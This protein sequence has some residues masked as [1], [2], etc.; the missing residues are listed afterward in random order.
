M[1]H[2]VEM[3]G[4]AF[5]GR[6]ALVTGANRG[7]GAAVARV[8]AAHGASVSLLVRDEAAGDAVRRTLPGRACVVVADVT[9][10]TA[11]RA[12]CERAAGEL[13][14]VHI[15]VNNAG[16]VETAPFTRSD[17]AL[18]ARMLA[19]HLYGPLHCTQAVLPDMVAEGFGR[20]VNIASTAGVAGAAYVSAYCAAKHALVGL[21]RSLAK[22][23]IGQG[24]T[25]NAVCPGYTD[26][27]LVSNSI[28]RI[29]SRTGRS[30]DHAKAAMLA[31]NPLGRFIQ[32]DEVAAAVRWLCE[33][34][35][36]SVTGQTIMIDG[37]ELA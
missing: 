10:E 9:D 1:T 37:G 17:P 3:Q 12:A 32:P 23:V 4:N 21:T 20:V 36:G 6:H 18:F 26:T 8:L 7:I 14:P 34:A 22:E 13:G 2:A 15:L 35:A 16:Y 25:V 28:E 33:A 27:D 29:T 5:S 24:I 11:V 19:V 30:A 31:G